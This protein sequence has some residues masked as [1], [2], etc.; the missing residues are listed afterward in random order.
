MLVGA[1]GNAGGQSTVLVVRRLALASKARLD[2]LST[3]GVR[4]IIVPEILVGAKLAVVLF[5]AA[6]LRCAIFKAGQRAVIARLRLVQVSLDS[7]EKYYSSFE[8]GQKGH[9]DVE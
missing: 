7:F 4:R 9:R 8:C 2:D 3:A 1:G 5:A 6:F